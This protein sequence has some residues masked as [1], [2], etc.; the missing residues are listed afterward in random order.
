MRSIL[1]VGG[2]TAGWMAAAYLNRVLRQPGTDEPIQITVVESQDI[3]IIGVGEATLP[4]LR[5]FLKTIDVPE[6]QFFTETDATLKNAI[7]FRQW[8]QVRGS[9][10]AHE[11][12]HPFEYPPTLEGRGADVHWMAL[13]DRGLDQPALC[14]AVGS[15]SELCRRYKSPQLFSGRPYESPMEY[16]YHLDTTKFGGFL[17]SLATSRGVTRIEDA[18]VG[19]HKSDIPGI[20][21][22]VTQSHGVLRAD[23]YI[24]ATGFRAELIGGALGQQFIDWSSYLLCDRAVAVQL[25]HLHEIPRLRPYTTATAQPAGW[26]WEIDLFT[27]RG[28][29]YVY[30]SRH[31]TAE[32]AERTLRVHLGPQA[33]AANARHLRMQ[34]GHRHNMWVGNCLAIGLAAGFMEPLE[35][36]GIFLIEKALGMFVDYCGGGEAGPYLAA[37]FNHK[38][39]QTYEEIRDFLQIHYV[40]SDRTDSQFWLDY[41]HDVTV[42]ESLKYKLDLWTFKMPAVTDLE[43]WLSTWGPGNYSYILAGMNRLPAQVSNT[44][45]Y[46][47]RSAS[48]RTLRGIEEMRAKIVAAHPDHYE[49]LN[50]SSWS[51]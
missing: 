47:S 12:Y 49:Y 6:W 40:L 44:S 25:P 35:S 28:N 43:G 7:L 14:D 41:T 2:G 34:I 22:V 11:Y 13:R 33:D 46:I 17:R 38:M 37:H 18:V 8:M 51:G 29:G 50:G 1:I 27:R 45:P 10:Q 21:H 39:R 19:V 36:T 16:A 20:A 15:Q 5:R 30:S 48:L 23:F 42:P 3:G 24:D 31:T 4:T 9:A 32:E 26:I